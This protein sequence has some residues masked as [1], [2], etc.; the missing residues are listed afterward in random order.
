MPCFHLKMYLYHIKNLFSMYLGKY[1]F[2]LNSSKQSCLLQVG[3]YQKGKI[4]ALIPN[5]TFGWKYLLEF[6][7]IIYFIIAIFFFLFFLIISKNSPIFPSAVLVV[8]NLTTLNKK[9][10]RT[11]TYCVQTVT[12]RTAKHVARKPKNLSY[13]CFWTSGWVSK[14][15]GFAHSTSN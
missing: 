15:F 11:R 4:F 3:L 1:I 12:G 14:N 10:L 13:F 9:I 5:V 6:L 7:S 2:T 8:K